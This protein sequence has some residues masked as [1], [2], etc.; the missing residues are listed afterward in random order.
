MADYTFD[1]Y[2]LQDQDLGNTEDI[3]SNATSHLGHNVHRRMRSNKEASTV[4]GMADEIVHV[5]NQNN[6]FEFVQD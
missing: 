4:S 6:R 5:D 2:R 3:Q 1:N